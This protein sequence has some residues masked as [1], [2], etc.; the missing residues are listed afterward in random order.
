MSLLNEIINDKFEEVA[1]R[2]KQSPLEELE[3]LAEVAAPTRGFA[4]RLAS[5]PGLALIA[6]IKRASPSKGMI[7]PEFDAME[8]ARMYEAAGATALSVLTDEKYFKGKLEYL[9]NARDAVG[10]P[11]LRKDF[12]IDEYQVVESRAHGADAILLI[13]AALGHT[14]LSEYHSLAGSLG[15]DVLVEVH[16]ESELFIALDMDAALIGVNNRNLDDFS[17]ELETTERLGPMLP[18]GAVLVSESGID[19]REDALRVARAGAK[20]ILVGESLM[21]A[22]DIVGKVR[23]LLGR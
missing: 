1:Q 18:K 15:L 11:L 22:P 8:I 21:R 19:D 16:T 4:S 10:L 3:Q 2:R 5:E 23:E 7:R 17:V 12:I 6:E 9:S 13:V 14:Q 20:A